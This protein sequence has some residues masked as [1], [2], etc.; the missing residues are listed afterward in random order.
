MIYFIEFALLHI[1]FYTVYHLMLSKE[2]E[3]R[4]LRGF[5]ISSTLLSLIVPS[6]S[7]PNA[8][9]PTVNTEAIM[10]PAFDITQTTE[11]SNS[12][13]WFQL[14][15][16]GV[17]ILIIAKLGL[18]LF[19]LLKF[20]KKSES[21]EIENIPVRDVEGLQN[22]FTFFRWI[23]IDSSYFE[24]P[25][26]IVRHESGHAKKLHSLD[27]IFF[28]SLSVIFWWVPSI[29]LMIRELRKV[30][31]FEADQYA[32][33]FSRETYIKTL[34]RSTLKAHGMNLASS[35]D[36]A[37][38][39]NRLN[40]IKQM[41]K[42]MNPWKIVSISTILAMSVAMF[43]CE[44]ELESE[45][46]RIA[47][48]SNQKIEYSAD[49]KAALSEL[50]AKN[51]EHEFAVIETKMD[52]EESI[53]RLNDHD[54]DQIAHVFVTKVGDEK[55]IVMIVNKSS[56]LFEKTMQVQK[57]DENGVYTIA[58]EAATFDGGI[59]AFNK[60]LGGTLKYPEQAQR[61]GV[62]GRVF[63]QFI[64]ETDGSISEVQ[65]VKGIGAGCDQEAMRVLKEAPRWIPGKVDGKP[66][67]QKMIQN[68][69]F[70]L[71]D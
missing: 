4:F 20:Y 46:K 31:E 6:L 65:I 70:S 25:K 63:V 15:L 64:V 1:L 55:T 38:I 7:I 16:I 59:D 11:I 43:A 21:M 37:P 23:F 17:G 68:I 42:K 69:K 28:Y 8:T 26:D 53:K 51:P 52:N 48:E 34:V 18:S 54:P 44:D 66:V 22:S 49:I 3:L 56:D 47:N 62:Q 32:L 50:K 61:L 24:N 13:D 67:R 33:S 39:F 35:F 29:W 45:I 19:Q 2:T 40:F 41:K 5:L 57:A 9:L 30:H 27:L 12:Y 58:E 60:Y 14:I 36:D 71:A 10:L